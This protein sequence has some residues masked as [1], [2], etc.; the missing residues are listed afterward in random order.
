MVKTAKHL[1]TATAV[2][3]AQPSE[4]PRKLSD[5]GGLLLEVRPEGGKW[6]RW[7]YRF[8][9]REKMLSLGTYPE[10]SLQEARTKR[11]ELAAVLA[12]GTDPSEARKA[13]KV[14]QQRQQEDADREAAGLPPAGSFEAVAREWLEMVHAGKVSEG[15]AD[16]T[17]I[18]L[19]QDI[20]P[21]LGRKPLA[22]VTAPMLLECLRRVEARGAIE[23]AH[24]V[25]Q[26]CGQVFRYGIATGAC[27]RNPAADLRDALKPVLVKHH[28]AITD[29]KRVG[30]LLRAVADYKGHPVTRAALALAPLLFQRPGELR[31][32]EWAEFD[33]EA[34]L[35]TIPGER[36]KRD[37]QGKATGPAHI[38]PL[39]R[40]AVAILRELQPLTA[41]RGA[42]VFPSLRTAHRPM[43]D[44][45]VLSALR[46]MGFPKEEMT[47]HGF[48][49]MART[50]LA[51]RLGVDEAVIEAQLAHAVKD[52]LGRAYNRT[53]F[54]EQRRLMMQTWADYLDRL[55]DGAQV[56][57]IRAA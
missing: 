45:A 23:T 25:K 8:G 46:R 4:K 28:A 55:R 34:G 50:M 22:S 21:W 38:V 3:N 14:D 20:F 42:Y 43:S 10:T 17:R 16:R 53:E 52:T 13:G 54:V 19:E 35:W 7:R 6:W 49:A 48:R 47:G 51:E 18:R 32:A 24:R 37:K 41:G 15:H 12:A 2:K 27:E 1:L 9:G 40:Q 31:K 5:G 11:D 39:S 57:A 56:V 26:A 36:M 29:P 44:N 33:L 30:E